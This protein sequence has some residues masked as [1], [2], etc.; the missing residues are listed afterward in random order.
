MGYIRHH[1]IAVTSW[2]NDSIQKAHEKAV[3][4]F[5]D[6]A[7]GILDSQ[8]NGYRSFF[9]GPDGSKLGWDESEIGNVQRKAFVNWINKQAYEDGS[10]ALSYCEFF[11]GD[12]EGESK[13]V[14]HN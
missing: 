10:S 7:S 3:E 4:I 5:K 12:D 9:I 8:T 14:N 1:A 11:Y 13:V 6:R 2:D